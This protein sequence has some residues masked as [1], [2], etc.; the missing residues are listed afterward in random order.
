M[1]NGPLSV[2]IGVPAYRN[3]VHTG[4][5]IQMANMSVY[6]TVNKLHMI[7]LFVDSSSLDWCRNR[8]LYDAV[9]SGCEWCLMVDSD[10][11]HPRAD[12]IYRMLDEG[13]RR[14]AA[15]IAAPVKMRN[16]PGYNVQIQTDG[17]P[18]RY[19]DVAEI[20]DTLVSVTHIGTALFAIRCGWI[21]RHWPEGPWFQTTQI[22][23]ARGPE[24]LG[25]DFGFCRGVAKRGGTVICDGRI[26]AAHAH[27]TNETELIVRHCGGE[28][29]E[30]TPDLWQPDPDHDPF[31][32]ELME[33]WG[34]QKAPPDVAHPD[35]ATA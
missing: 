33:L 2:A 27:A 26:E 9:R 3:Q 18:A 15:V 13:N 5:V 28:L 34:G 11:Y 17:G 32:D 25:E 12:W 29:L 6:A 20:K 30:A 14:R 4:L 7:L 21:V 19:L 1:V 31:G 23:T 8:L 35:G 24:K 10:T 16:R 22:V